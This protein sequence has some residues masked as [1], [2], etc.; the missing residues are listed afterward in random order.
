MPPAASVESPR[1]GHRPERREHRRE[2]RPE[3]RTQ[4]RTIAPAVRVQSDAERHHERPAPVARPIAP[5]V[6]RQLGFERRELRHDQHRHGNSQ[7]GAREG[8]HW[9]QR[10]G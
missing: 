10:P 5:A 2:W 1:L 7:R 4:V 6:P 3:P 8:K 9:G